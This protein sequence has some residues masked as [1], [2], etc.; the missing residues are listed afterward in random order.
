MAPVAVSVDRPTTRTA[1]DEVPYPGHPHAETHPNRLAAIARLFGIEAP[2]VSTARVL[3][4]ACGDGA[5]LLPI[6]YSLPQARCTGLDLAATAVE[7]ARNRASGLQL[8]NVEVLVADLARVEDL[9]EFDYIVAHGLYSWV[10]APLRDAL[11]RFVARS[12]APRGIA[13]VSYNTFPGWHVTGMVREMLRYHTRATSD[14]GER[15]RQ[16]RALLDFLKVAHDDNDPYGRLLGA[17]CERIARHSAGHLFHD[18]L[19]EVNDPVYFEEFVAHA[20]QFGLAYVADADFATMSGGELPES[21]QAKLD[22]LRGDPVAHG[23]YLDFVRCR[24]FRESLLCSAGTRPSTAP[25]HGA[26]RALLAASAATAVES[27]VD[28]A[29]GVEVE[30][31]W[32]ERASLRTGSSVAKAALIALRERWPEP[33]AFD[34]LL[35]AVGH[36]LGRAPTLDDAG[37]LEEVLCAAFGLRMVELTAEPW[38]CTLEHGARPR[39]SLLARQ[40]A[41]SGD[42]LTTLSHRRVRVDEELAR[43]LLVLCDG[44]RDAA[45]LLETLRMEGLDLD[46]GGLQQ[47]VQALAKLCLLER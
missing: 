25:V 14:P 31:R 21:A 11:L 39:A 18:D 40:E 24:R 26:A 30:F 20:A 34:T 17:E 44:S 32:G 8:A 23:Q 15:V 2:R 36:W 46:P 16:A 33:V 3:E 45:A 29:D 37:A 27:P 1:Y 43:R 13:F 41:G 12:L 47:R 22:E 6:A 38:N 28:L 35:A 42:V 9:G 5:N 10:P 7:R 4:I 19:A